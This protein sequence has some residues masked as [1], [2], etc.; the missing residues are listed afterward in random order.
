MLDTR[1]VLTALI[2]YKVVLILIGFWA[3][4]RVNSEQDFSSPAGN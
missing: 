1:V 2:V 3:Q 4:R